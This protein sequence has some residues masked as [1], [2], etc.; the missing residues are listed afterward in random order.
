MANEW[1]KH[2]ITVN[3]LAPGWMA[4]AN[5][6]PLRADAIRNKEILD[7]IPAGRWGLPDDVGGPIVFLCS[8]AA[9][10]VTG[11]ILAVD[12]GWLSR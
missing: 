12:G 2:E 4:T 5:T 10:Y 9:S 1:A 8:A 6:A 7:R 3:A 11:H